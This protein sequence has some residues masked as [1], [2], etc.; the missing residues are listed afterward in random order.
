MGAAVRWGVGQEAD[1]NVSQAF[2]LG[3]EMPKLGDCAHKI[4]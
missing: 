1:F 3:A 2:C 4:H